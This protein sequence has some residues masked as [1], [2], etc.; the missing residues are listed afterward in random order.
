[1][2]RVTSNRTKDQGESD[3]ACQHDVNKL[4]NVSIKL[5]KTVNECTLPQLGTTC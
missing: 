4:M 3:K 5:N 2:S 1:M